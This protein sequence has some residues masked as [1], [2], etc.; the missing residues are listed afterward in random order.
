MSDSLPK[1]SII[2]PSYNQVGTIETALCSVLEQ[3]YPKVE[4]IVIDGGSTDGSVEIIQRYAEQLAFWVSE[5]DKGI[6]DAMNKGIE[7]ATGEFLLFLGT[8][9]KLLS[10]V[11]REV[12]ALGR[13]AEAHFI[14]GNYRSGEHYAPKRPVLNFATLYAQNTCHQAIFYQA[15]L[16]QKLGNYNTRYSI[17]ADWDFNLRC[18]AWPNLKVHYADVCICDFGYGG[19][20]S[21][22]EDK[23]FL[24]ERFSRFSSTLEQKPKEVIFALDQAFQR[25]WPLRYN[26][27]KKQQ[28]INQI[29]AIYNTRGYRFLSF[30][31]RLFRR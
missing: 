10:C 12:F 2:I 11:L 9:D 23:L 28:E 27:A 5:P 25:L 7:K 13:A 17:Y 22:R 3:D 15:S 1:I 24:E 21:L 20:S 14:Y 19:V 30:L 31:N 29:A 8:D 16:F 26:L 6:Y 18:F 4:C